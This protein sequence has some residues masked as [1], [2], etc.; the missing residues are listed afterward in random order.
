MNPPVRFPDRLL[1]EAVRHYEAEHGAPSDETDANAAARAVEGDPETRLVIRA[2]ALAI[3][4]ALSTALVRV[5]HAVA[6]CLGLG[7]LLALSAGAAAARLALWPAPD[8]PVN[9]YWLL[10][11][12]LGLPLLT[13]LLW[14]I[15]L[16]I[17]TPALAGGS[18]GALVMALGERLGRYLHREPAQFAA[19]RAAATLLTDR[20]SL[21]AISHALWLSYLLGALAMALLLLG[22]RQYGFIWESTLLS[23]DSYAILTRTL[24]WLPAQ[25]GFAPPDAAQIA[26]SQRVDQPPALDASA[27][28]SGLVLG[29]LTVYGILPRLILL[30]LCLE[31]RRRHRKAFRLDTELPGHARLHD[32]LQPLSMPLGVIDPDRDSAAPVRITDTAVEV[33]PQDTGPPAILGLEID[34]P[35]DWPPL[36][37]DWLDLGPIDDRA[38]RQRALDRLRDAGPARVV[39]VCSLA[40]TPDRG[41]GRFLEQLAALGQPLLLVLSEGQRMR[42]RGQGAD[43]EQRI[44]DWRSLVERAGLDENDIMELDLDHLTPVSR[45]Q[46]ADALG[47]STEATEQ[48]PIERAFER[49][50]EHAGRWRRP[51]DSAEQAELHRA[52]AREHGQRRE[53]FRLPLPS[54]AE[55]QADPRGQLQRSAERVRRLLPARLR[56]NPRWLATGA[57]TGALGCVAIATVTAPAALAALPLWAAVGATLSLFTS[58]GTTRG[59]SASETPDFGEA[60]AAAALFALLLDLQDRD[61]ATIT[62]ALDELLDDK[63][64]PLTSVVAIRTWLD[65]LAAR[66]R[67][68]RERLAA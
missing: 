5:R 7:L 61:E 2:R 66:H 31:L 32:A 46:L 44:A 30:L 11:S 45:K 10:I 64:P 16:T 6:L 9:V 59:E 68:L 4:P 15:L 24:A 36:A 8:Q 29:C 1:A 13:L 47:W 54:H 49:I 37:G 57:L 20:W 58:S 19:N 22:V 42:A 28:W 60:V 23:A 40:M 3:A 43:L 17:R 35:D 50:V 18:L 39:V 48:V 21:S 26:A 56:G 52:I 62:R 41:H 12:L 51:P 65:E 53:A 55:L 27:A 67:A 63:P 38:A 34:L 33:S 14:L 25:F